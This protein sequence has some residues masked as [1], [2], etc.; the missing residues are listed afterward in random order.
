MEEKAREKEKEKEV[1]PEELIEKKPQGKIKLKHQQKKLQQE[2]KQT[3]TKTD[4]DEEVADVF[5]VDCRQLAYEK[6]MSSIVNL[7]DYKNGCLPKWLKPPDHVPRIIRSANQRRLEAQRE[8]DMMLPPDRTPTPGRKHM[9]GNNRRRITPSPLSVFSGHSNQLPTAEAHSNS[10]TVPPISIPPPSVTPLTSHRSHSSH[11]SHISQQQ[12]PVQSAHHQSHQQSTSPSQ[13]LFT[14]SPQRCD[15]ANMGPL[16]QPPHARIR[17]TKTAVV[18]RSYVTASME[19]MKTRHNELTDLEISTPQRTKSSMSGF[20]ADRRINKPFQHRFSLPTRSSQAKVTHQPLSLS[21]SATRR[22]PI[23][24][25]HLARTVKKSPHSYQHSAL[26]GH[27]QKF[28]G[29]S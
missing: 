18:R 26:I 3:D 23:Y 16:Y 13:P 5:V 19:D 15:S 2:Q 21:S 25:H 29:R 20:I 22:K 7:I 17:L 24:A 14:P 12:K 4:S 8:K 9:C 6:E 27:K 11:H 28:I 10:L 1:E